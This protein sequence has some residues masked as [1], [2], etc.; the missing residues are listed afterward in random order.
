[1]EC[2]VEHRIDSIEVVLGTHV[3]G[4]ITGLKLTEADALRRV[5]DQVMAGGDVV[6]LATGR[7][8]RSMLREIADGLAGQRCR[9]LQAAA[10]PPAM[11][12]LPAMMAQVIG[13]SSLD[14]RDDKVLEVGFRVLTELDPACDRVVLLIGDAHAL[15][16]SALRY[17]QFASHTGAGLQLVFLGK[18]VLFE[19]LDAAEFTPLRMGLAAHPPIELAPPVETPVMEPD[20]S[21]MRPPSPA[22]ALGRSLAPEVRSGPGLV[23][24]EALVGT[25]GTGRRFAKTAAAGLG[26]AALLAGGFWLGR[27]ERMPASRDEAVATPQIPSVADGQSGAPHG[28]GLAAATQPRSGLPVVTDA[29]GVPGNIVAP[30]EG[31]AEATPPR[32]DVVVPTTSALD[33]AAEGRGAIRPSGIVPQLRQVNVSPDKA[34]AAASGA[35]SRQTSSAHVRA[36]AGLQARAGQ[37]ERRVPIRRV[38]AAKN[39]SDAEETG[40]NQSPASLGTFSVGPDGVRSFHMGQ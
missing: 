15:Q 25:S 16:R 1:M 21:F 6:V 33:A 9:V 20:T 4:L 14:G 23:A 19:M 13:R 11:L 18:P 37:E 7:P 29:A 31:R 34:P 35:E 39:S 24:P 40:R 36:V 28:A 17:L 22:A 10:V 5:L 27:H 2:F 26:V 12:S 8:G 38:T 32:A 3:T 30:Q